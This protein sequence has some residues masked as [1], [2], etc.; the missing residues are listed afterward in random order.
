MMDNQLMVADILIW[1]ATNALLLIPAV[2]G[3]VMLV[4]FGGFEGG[5]FSRKGIGSFRPAIHQR[6]LSRFT[7]G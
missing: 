4:R 2:I 3:L 7:C 6:K 1:E 5:P